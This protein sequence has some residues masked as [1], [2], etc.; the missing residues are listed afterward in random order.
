M[1]VEILT[2]DKGLA[3]VLP[4][5]GEAAYLRAKA[6]RYGWFKSGDFVLP[7]I[8]ERRALFDRLVFTHQTIWLNGGG[9]QSGEYE[10]LNQ[11]VAAAR[12]LDVDFIYQPQATAVF[13]VVPEGAIYARFGTYVVDLELPVE[14][15]WANVHGKHRNVIKKAQDAGVE[16]S[17]GPHNLDTCY[18]LIHSTMK[19]N[20][21]L[22]VS[23]GEL[24]RFKT[25]LAGNVSFYVAKK[26]NVAQ[27]GAV[28]VWSAGH[29]AYYLHGG[30]SDSPFGGAMNLLHWKAMNDMK[31]RGVRQYDFVGARV[32]PQPGSKLETI[33]RFKVRFGATMR[34][35]YLWKYPL[36]P[37][38]YTAYQLFARANSLMHGAAYKG[39]LI[40]EERALV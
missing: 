20:Q 12:N 6:S 18:E 14:Q 1:M 13:S 21:K 31:T 9:S 25:N 5:V 40:D 26:D 11:V 36:K 22:S 37:L 28:I 10:F 34:E 23:L 8:V 17:D 33:Q 32:N 27:G 15:L 7:F 24:E 30:T 35:G 16:I 39:D 29:T 3:G 38:R 2:T 4:I 19:R